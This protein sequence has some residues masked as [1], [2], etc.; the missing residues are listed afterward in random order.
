M[1]FWVFGCDA[2]TKQ[3]R[4]PLYLE[5]DNEAA[6]RDL[7]AQAG[8]EVEFVNRAFQP[9]PNPGEAGPKAT[10][11]ASDSSTPTPERNGAGSGSQ[12]KSQGRTTDSLCD[13]EPVEP[14]DPR[15]PDSHE[16]QQQKPAAP[17]DPPRDSAPPAPASTGEAF[18]E[19]L[20]AALGEQQDAQGGSGEP[21]LGPAWTGCA[22][23]RPEV[24]GTPQRLG[25]LASGD[26]PRAFRAGW[27]VL[28]LVSPA[29]PG[30][31]HAASAHAGRPVLGRL[32]LVSRLPR[33]GVY[34]PAYRGP[35]PA[36][37]RENAPG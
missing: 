3:L 7:A 16:P 33:G 18:E 14:L 1:V 22:A 2:Q 8:M 13:P 25:S 6:A 20:L 34:P 5:V 21:K 12:R 36:W 11:T 26:H 24:G 17:R 35:G 37:Q 27:P 4:D 28:G 15:G 29:S 32:G 19:M 9:S 23:I 10:L 30:R 31:L